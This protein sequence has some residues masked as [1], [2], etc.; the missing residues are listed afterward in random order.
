MNSEKEKSQEKKTKMT[1]DQNMAFLEKVIK[2]WEEE[3]QKEGS[4]KPQ[5][6]NK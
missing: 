2:I 1:A 5:S 3:K 4:K 6:K